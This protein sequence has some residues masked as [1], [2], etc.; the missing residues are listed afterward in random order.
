MSRSRRAV[1]LGLTAAAIVLSAAWVVSGVPLQAA[2]PAATTATISIEDV[3]HGAAPR[4]VKDVKPVYPEEAKKDGVQGLFVID[5]VIG[6]DGAVR[7]T[8]LVESAPTPEAKVVGPAKGAGRGPQGDPR[9]ARAALDAVRQW[10]FEPIAVAGR[11]VE[12]HL[13]VTVAFKLDEKKVGP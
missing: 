4:K 12:A 9:L 3:A 6:P 7:D 10:Q 5:V 2:K 1:H 11:P 8:K 13:T